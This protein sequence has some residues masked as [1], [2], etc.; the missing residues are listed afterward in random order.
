MQQLNLI[1]WSFFTETHL[2]EVKRNVLALSN[3]T[4]NHHGNLRVSCPVSLCRR[5][6]GGR[7][8]SLIRS[9]IF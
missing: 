7:P 8:P 1:S 5:M 4:A 9:R 3:G 2:W 6:S